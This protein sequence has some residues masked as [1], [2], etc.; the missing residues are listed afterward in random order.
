[1]YLAVPTIAYGQPGYQEAIAAA[2]SIN[3]TLGEA[4]ES[5]FQTGG[6]LVA[7]SAWRSVEREIDSCHPD[8]RENLVAE[9]TH[10]DIEN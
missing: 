3:R 1:M 2:R 9:E 8:I 7:R 6:E 4:G 5:I 10:V